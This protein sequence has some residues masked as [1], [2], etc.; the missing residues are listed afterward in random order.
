MSD[1][2]GEGDFRYEAVPGWGSLPAGWSLRE[3]AAVAVDSQDRV[4]AFNRGEQ[5]MVIFDREVP[6][7]ERYEVKVRSSEE[8]FSSGYSTQSFE[9]SD[10]KEIESSFGRT[11]RGKVTNTGELPAQFVEVIMVFY[12]EEDRVVDASSCYATTDNDHAIQPG[13]S[14]NF[15]VDY[16]A[17]EPFVRYEFFVEGAQVKP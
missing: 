8:G 1:I 16:L 6:E 13:E 10:D 14:R 17:D 5:P 3:V 2:F 7:F 12:D 9:V 15:E 4:Y 11:F